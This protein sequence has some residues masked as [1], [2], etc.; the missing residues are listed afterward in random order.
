[1]PDVGTLD[2][3][4]RRRRRTILNRAQAKGASTDQ[5]QRFVFLYRTENA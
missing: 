4:G 5:A 2:H 3:L 1:M